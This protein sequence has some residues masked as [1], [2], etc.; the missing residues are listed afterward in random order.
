[1]ITSTHNPRVQAVRKLQAQAKERRK[2][3]SFVV[4]GVR[5]VE[6]AL[7][8]GWTVKQVFFTGQLDE[9]GQA[10]VDRFAGR[11]V[12]IE[13][14]NDTVMS[15]ISETETPQGLLAVVS[16]QTPP[17]PPA[18]DFVLILDRLR[19]PGNLGTILRTAL[20]AGVQ[21]VLLAPGC[22]DAWSGKVL[23]AGMGA[24]FH[25]PIHS[26][27]WPDIIGILKGSSTGLRIYLAD[28]GEGIIYTHADFKAPTAIVVGGEAAGAGM[29]A[30]SLADEKVHIPM[31]GGGESLNA[32]VAASILLF[33]VVRQRGSN[34]KPD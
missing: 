7:Q 12:P 6:E 2:G 16:Q 22:V 10:V 32:A 29:E 3:Q 8:A 34:K 9:R 4:E 18:P 1:M 17:L 14:V 30:L 25:L 21:G 31:P 20:A 15:S 19:D 27:R 28:S 13:Q 24:H 26:L 5:L 11:R 33:E 23:R